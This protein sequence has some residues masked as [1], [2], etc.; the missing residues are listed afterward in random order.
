MLGANHVVRV[1]ALKHIGYY[2]GHLTEDLITGMTLHSKWYR[3]K[4]VPLQLAVGEGPATWP[5]YFNQQMRWATGCIDILFHYSFKRFSIM[6]IKHMMN[7]FLLQQHYFSGLAS[8][9]GV[10]FLT[11]YFAFGLTPTNMTL[12]PFFVL[13]IPLILWQLL[14]HRWLQR[15][16]INPK[17]DKGILIQ[18]MLLSIMVWPIYFLSL[19]GVIRGKKLSFKVTPKGGTVPQWAPITVFIP[20]LIIGLVALVEVASSI[21]TGRQSIIMLF[22]ASVTS[23]F[24]L[25]ITLNETLF[26]RIRIARA[27]AKKRRIEPTV[28]ADIFS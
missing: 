19:V 5:A 28:P 6:R 3:S 13:Y 2:Y 17:K 27:S 12:A 24:M 20:H 8:M 22:W 9:L 4:Y 16:Y 21:E 23:F 18:N 1:S 15:F 10:L 7:Y 25:G 11:L 14:I 26:A